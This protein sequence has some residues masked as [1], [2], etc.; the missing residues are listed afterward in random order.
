MNSTTVTSTTIVS[1]TSRRRFVHETLFISASVATKKSAKPG[2]FT[3]R[4]PTQI[5]K[6]PRMIGIKR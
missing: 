6:T 5:N 1:C 4:Q 2:M 3:A